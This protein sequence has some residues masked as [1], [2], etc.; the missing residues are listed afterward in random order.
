MMVV[1]LEIRALQLARMGGVIQ[2]SVGGG[3]ILPFFWLG[4]FFAL[5]KSKGGSHVNRP[6]EVHCLGLWRILLEGDSHCAIR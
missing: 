5:L 4:E 2:D 6:C 3:V 1:Q